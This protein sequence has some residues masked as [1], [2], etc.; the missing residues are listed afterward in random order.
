MKAITLWPEW[1]YAIV[2]LG[3]DG[4]NRTWRLWDSMIG[5]PIAIHAGVRPIAGKISESRYDELMAFKESLNVVEVS[6]D[7]CGTW[8]DVN[9]V[10]GHIVQI[11]TFGQPTQD[12][13]SPWAAGDGQWFWP[14]VSRIEIVPVKCKG[15]QGLWQVP[16][17]V[18]DAIRAQGTTCR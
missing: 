10:R 7:V 3:K 18:L 4:E 17:D 11:V 14:I 15:A 1:A 6:V 16:A 13:R 5:Q 9:A 12:S 2:R 8:R